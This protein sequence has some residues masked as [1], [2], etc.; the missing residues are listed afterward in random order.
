MVRP[1]V[2]GTAMRQEP[3]DRMW[4]QDRA[5]FSAILVATG[6]EIWTILRVNIDPCADVGPLTHPS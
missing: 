4:V 2:I 5:A 3:C 6:G 1:T